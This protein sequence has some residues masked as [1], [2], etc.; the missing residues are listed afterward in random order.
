[1]KFNLNLSLAIIASA[2]VAVS[3]CGGSGSSE[4]ASSESTAAAPPAPVKEISLEEKYKDDPVY[5]KGVELMGQND[6]ASCHM[7]EEKS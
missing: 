7:L 2:L 4:S 3:A 6:C 5:I 1:M